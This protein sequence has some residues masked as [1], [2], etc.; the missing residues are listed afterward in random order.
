MEK[1]LVFNSF[2]LYP[3]KGLFLKQTSALAGAEP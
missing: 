1:K 3:D 2:F